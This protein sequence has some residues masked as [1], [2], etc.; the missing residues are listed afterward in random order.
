MSPRFI[1]VLE[2]VGALRRPLYKS[3]RAVSHLMRQI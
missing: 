3:Y 1:L 2:A